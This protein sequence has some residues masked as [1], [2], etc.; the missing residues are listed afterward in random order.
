MAEVFEMRTATGELAYEGTISQIA[1][2]L[3]VSKGDVYDAKNT[4]KWLKDY[5]I[6]H[7]TKLVTRSDVEQHLYDE[8]GARRY[9]Y[10]HGYPNRYKGSSGVRFTPL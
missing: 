7:S 2:L 10:K 9:E 1:N 4:G 6:I 5:K 8:R 3:K